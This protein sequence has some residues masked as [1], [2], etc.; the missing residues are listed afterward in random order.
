VVE[1]VD[2]PAAELER[3]DEAAQIRCPL[4]Q[5]DLEAGLRKTQRTGEAEDSAADD[6][7]RRPVSAELRAHARVSGAMRWRAIMRQ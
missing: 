1:A 5:R 2:L 4:V 6:A 3:A 7:D